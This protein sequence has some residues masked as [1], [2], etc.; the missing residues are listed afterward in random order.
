MA[1]Q[2]LELGSG[3]AGVE[4]H[5]HGAR[6]VHGGVGRH[7]PQRFLGGDVD[8]HTLTLGDAGLRQAPSEAVR[9]RLPRPEG[10]LAVVED[11]E[12]DLVGHLV[13]HQPE[14]VDEQLAWFGAH[15][16]HRGTIRQ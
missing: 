3:Q 5:G 6:L 11:G 4:G 9:R 7:P 8:R 13:R 12:G 15:G 16:G 2:G 10:E 1:E 14:L